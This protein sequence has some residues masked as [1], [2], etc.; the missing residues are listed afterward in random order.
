MALMLKGL[1]KKFK[2]TGAWVAHL[3]ERAP[4]YR[5]S[6]LDAAAAGSVPQAEQNLAQHKAQPRIGV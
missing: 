2:E 5:G 1:F 3:G 6:V 4:I